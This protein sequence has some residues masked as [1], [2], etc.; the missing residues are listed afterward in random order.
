MSYLVSLDHAQTF[1]PDGMLQLRISAVKC[2]VIMHE[3]PI[4][5]YKVIPQWYVGMYVLTV[6]R[7]YVAYTY[8]MVGASEHHTANVC[9]HCGNLYSHQFGYE[10]G[11]AYLTV[12]LMLYMYETSYLGACLCH[13]STF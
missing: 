5:S 13:T 2:T 7:W 4:V 3:V 10:L 9:A 8:C 11:S 12:W 6:P 1:P